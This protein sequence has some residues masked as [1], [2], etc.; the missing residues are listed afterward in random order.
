MT[1]PDDGPAVRQ[2][3]RPTARRACEV[4]VADEHRRRTCGAVR[5][6]AT[7]RSSARRGARPDRRQTLGTLATLERSHGQFYNWYDPRHGAAPDDLARRTAAGLPVPLHASTTAGS[8]TALL[9][10]ERAVPEPRATQ[11][12]ALVDAMDFGFYYD[13]ATP[14]RPDPRRLLDEDPHEAAGRSTGNSGAAAPTSG[15]PCHHYGALNTEPRIASYLGI[16]LGPDPAASTTS[17]PYRTFPE[18]QLRLELA[19][20]QAG[21]RLEDVPRRRRLR[22]RATLPRHERRPDLGRQHVRGADGAAVRAG[23]GVGPASWGVNHPLY[24]RGADRARAATRRSTATGAS[25]RRT[26]P[27][28][29]TASTASTR[30]A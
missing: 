15:T 23:G 10:V 25:R 13:P 24:V 20:D 14:Q 19:G 27:P 12:E 30:S 17:A 29:A 7:C 4:H 28:A 11:A 3:H 2:R 9:M 26:T 16:A 21:R 18:R 1:E 6:R 8:A 22:G 5:R